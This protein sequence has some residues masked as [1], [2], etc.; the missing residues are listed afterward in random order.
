MWSERLV[1]LASLFLILLALQLVPLQG[2]VVL[3]VRKMFS[4]CSRVTNL[5]LT[6]KRDGGVPSHWHT[7]V[8]DAAGELFLDGLAGRMA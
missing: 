3:E 1:A 8:Y 6:A 4:V 2:L 7:S 5:P